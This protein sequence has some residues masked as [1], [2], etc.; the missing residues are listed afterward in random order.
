[1]GKTKR[2]RPQQ[3]D[4]TNETKGAKTAR[5][6]GAKNIPITPGNDVC[7]YHRYKTL[8]PQIVGISIPDN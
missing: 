3:Q 6:S 5:T 7:T 1:M 8:L 2:K 4:S